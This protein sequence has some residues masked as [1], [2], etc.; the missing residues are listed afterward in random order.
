MTKFT[1][2]RVDI[3]NHEPYQRIFKQGLVRR[4]Q[5]VQLGARVRDTFIFIE[6]ND[7]KSSNTD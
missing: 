7:L 4:W 2:I 5:V 1:M 6:Y 3:A